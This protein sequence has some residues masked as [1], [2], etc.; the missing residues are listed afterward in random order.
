MTG[1]KKEVNEMTKEGSLNFKFKFFAVF[2]FILFDLSGCVTVD[3]GN[4]VEGAESIDE[5]QISSQLDEELFSKKLPEMTADEYEMLGDSLFGKGNLSLAFLQYERSLQ[6]NPQN[7]R[8]EY[9]KGLTLLAGK[10]SDDAIE[11]FKVVLEKN[12]GYA[13]AYEGLG[14]AFFQKKHWREAEQNFHK[15][16]EIDPMLWKSYNFLGNIYDYQ[17]KYEKAIEAYKNALA[18]KPKNGLVYNNLGVSYSLAGKYSLAVDAFN[19]ALS[20][21]YTESKVYNNLGLA[22]S[23]LGRYS[24]ALEAFKKGGGEAR[25]YNN[26][27][28]IYLSKGMM[29]EAVRCFEK[30]IEIDPVFYARANENLNRA[31]I[32][33]ENRK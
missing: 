3:K 19:K 1:R 12:L 18:F 24:E 4:K 28:C 21:K 10:K 31:K 22:L 5:I 13:A 16:L 32:G 23:N 30:A 7:I 33:L 26:L 14:R 2:F 20:V 25:A 17:A 8:V 29:E 15:A 11:Q 27:G 9:K 6:C